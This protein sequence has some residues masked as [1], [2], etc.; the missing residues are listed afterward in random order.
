MSS[1][2]NFRF[3]ASR[4]RT[5]PPTPHWRIDVFEIYWNIL[6]FGGNSNGRDGHEKCVALCSRSDQ[7]LFWVFWELGGKGKQGTRFLN[8]LA[9]FVPTLKNLPGEKSGQVPAKSIFYE[10]RSNKS[11]SSCPSLLCVR[12]YSQMNKVNCSCCMKQNILPEVV[13]LELLKYSSEKKERKKKIQQLLF[14]N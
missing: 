10:N 13:H 14:L 9:Y 8:N 4:L 2:N 5:F 3:K 7:D 12:C 1:L 11:S 6:L